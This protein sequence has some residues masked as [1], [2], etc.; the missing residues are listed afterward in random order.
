MDMRQLRYFVAIA[1][2]GSFGRAAAAL[3]VAQSALSR[4]MAVLEEELGGALFERSKRGATLSESGVLLLDRARYLLAEIDK[5]RDEVMAHN[6]ELR[7]SVRLGGP[8]SLTQL[9][10]A[11]LVDC[12]LERFPNVQLHLSEGLTSDLID[13]LMDGSLDIAIVTDPRPS[14]HLLFQPVVREPMVLI[15]RADDPLLKRPSLSIKYLLKLPLITPVSANWLPNLAARFGEEFGRVRPVVRVDSTTPMKLLAAAG[16]GY[17]VVP[18][19]ALQGDVAA[20]HLAACELRGFNVSRE[21]AT[22]RGRPAAR[23]VKEMIAVLHEQIGLLVGS[24][25]IK[26]VVA[27]SKR[28]RKE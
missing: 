23:A 14:E 17:G 13:R 27:R 2:R 19:S 25:K 11:P 8:S 22:S 3:Y 7:G 21:I 24:G 4:H 15:G 18:S 9:L 28:L 1:E 26:A 10:Y 6:R 16:K 20:G 5:T 12:F